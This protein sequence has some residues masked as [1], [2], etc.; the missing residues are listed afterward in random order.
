MPL[1]LRRAGTEGEHFDVNDAD[2]TVVVEN[3]YQARSESR[4]DV[5]GPEDDE[6]EEEGARENRGLLTIHHSPAGRA[7][8]QE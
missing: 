4:Q 3:V 1:L 5:H 2:P 8:A 7:G 6:Q